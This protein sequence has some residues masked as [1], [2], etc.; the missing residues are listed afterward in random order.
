MPMYKGQCHCG[1]N[2]YSVD[3]EPEFQF[4]CHCEG[5]RVINGAG[6]LAGIL[7][8]AT[9]FSPAMEAKTYTYPGGSGDPVKMHFC[10]TCGTHLY[11]FPTHYP[12]KVVLRANTLTEGDFKPEHVLFPESAFKWDKP[13]EDLSQQFIQ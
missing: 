3:A 13:R 4:E 11:A 8:D 10:S 2:K 5:C 6:H 7:V 12:D 9:E 1:K